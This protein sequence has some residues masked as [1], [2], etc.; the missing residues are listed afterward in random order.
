MFDIAEIHFKVLEKIDKTN[1]SKILIVV[2]IKEFSF[3]SCQRI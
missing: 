1:K 2:T 3:R